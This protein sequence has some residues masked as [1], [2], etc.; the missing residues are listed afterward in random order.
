MFSI[1]SYYHCLKTKGEIQKKDMKEGNRRAVRSQKRA[2]CVMG[3]GGEEAVV[4]GEW[5]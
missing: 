3:K 2:E 1:W 5:E 4:Q